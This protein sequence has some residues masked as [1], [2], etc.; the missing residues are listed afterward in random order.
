[1][2]AKRDE[3]VT[4]EAV[5]KS[6][7]GKKARCTLTCY[8]CLKV[9]VVYTRNDE[10]YYAAREALQQKLEMVSHRFC[11]GNL[12]YD[13]DHPLSQI[14]CQ[15]QNLTCALP[16]EKGYYNCKDRS[17]KLPDVCYHCGAGG[18]KQFVLRTEELRERGLSGGY[19][20]FPICVA[21]LRGGKKV[22]TKGRKNEMQARKEKAMK[23][24]AAKGG[25]KTGQ[26]V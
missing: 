13:D 14:L 9:R 17:L 5:L 26:L 15:K 6:W 19:N 2:R 1:M 11:C 22:V 18:D 4:K 16:I 25:K 21:C 10:A 7:D 23:A 20:C 8:E 12:L 24:K 3:R